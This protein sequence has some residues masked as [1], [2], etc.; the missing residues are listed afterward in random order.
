MKRGKQRWLLAGAAI[1]ALAGGISA[2]I[3]TAGFLT[4][5]HFKGEAGD[6]ES[7]RSI[8]GMAGEIDPH[9]RDRRN[10][11]LAENMKYVSMEQ[12]VVFEEGAA[13]GYAGIENG[14]ESIL[15][16]Q[17][18][19]IR[20]ATGEALYQSKMID[21]GYYIETIQLSTSLKKGY[22]PC[23]AVWRFYERETDAPVG[24][25]AGKIVVIVER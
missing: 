2:G 21:P 1:L 13:P 14:Q 23:T 25:T 22:Y 24:S 11:L 7:G 9:E 15:G 12:K 20:D 5:R 19:I 17:V 16:C 3:G 18:E 8:W 4:Q 10:A 6:R